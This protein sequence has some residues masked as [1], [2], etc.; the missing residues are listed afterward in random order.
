[1]SAAADEARRPP[2][3]PWRRRGHQTPATRPRGN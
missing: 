2:G 1:M 3:G